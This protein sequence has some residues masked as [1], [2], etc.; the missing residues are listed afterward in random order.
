MDKK[1][2]I[3]L[4][5]IVIISGCIGQ[6][7][8]TC[9]P[10]VNDVDISGLREKNVGVVG[11]Y[12]NGT[13]SLGFTECFPEYEFSHE[14]YTIEIRKDGKNDII[15]SGTL[16]NEN[17]FWFKRILDEDGIWKIVVKRTGVSVDNQIIYDI[18]ETMLAFE[19][20]APSDW[21]ARQN[22]LKRTRIEESKFIWTIIFSFLGPFITYI[23]MIRKERK[24]MKLI[25]KKLEELTKELKSIK[26]LIKKRFHFTKL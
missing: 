12:I 9:I 20:M 5:I 2:L 25:V 6:G 21:R 11:D 19:V 23:L 14:N 22:E 24:E 17:V 13:I 3:V 10:F 7:P 8:Y 18:S 26:E 15:S 1:L 16:H 4:I